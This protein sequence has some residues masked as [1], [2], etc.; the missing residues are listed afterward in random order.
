MVRISVAEQT[1]LS[2]FL[3]RRGLRRAT[4]RASNL[5]LLPW[6]M[7][8]NKNDRLLLSPQDLRTADGTRASEIYAGRFAF[9]GKVVICDGRSP[10]EMNPPS[11]E[12]AVELYGFGW[13]RHL[14]AADSGDHARQ[15]AR[16]GRRMDHLSGQLARARLAHRCAG[17][18][19]HVL[20]QPGAADPA[21]RRRPVLSPLHAQPDPA[22]ALPAP[23]RLRSARWRARFAGDDRADVCL[24][25]HGEPGAPHQGERQEARRPARRA[26]AGRWRTCQPP[27]RRHHRIAARPAAAETGLHQPQRRAAAGI[28]E[29]ASTA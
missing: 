20:D 6:R 28:A 26:G 5:P 2:L 18:A 17:A 9:G 21:G 4:S 24:A 12:W 19:R 8:H 13:L 25:L 23:Q 7:I 14:R 27:S 1:R 10:F 29:R 22:G 11:E 3:M 15:C 16:A